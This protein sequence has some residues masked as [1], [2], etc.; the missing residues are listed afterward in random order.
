MNNYILYNDC[1]L[2]LSVDGLIYYYNNETFI[3]DL[4]AQRVANV[5]IWG[6]P[7]VFGNIDHYAYTHNIPKGE[8]GVKPTAPALK[9]HD[10][11][12]IYFVR[13]LTIA[14]PKAGS[15]NRHKRL[16]TV[17]YYNVQQ[18]FGNL[19]FEEALKA[20]NIPDVGDDCFKLGQ[21]ILAYE[22]WLKCLTG[23]DFFKP[24]G[25]LKYYSTGS[26]AKAYYLSLKY[27]FSPSPLKAY[28][29][30]FPQ[31]EKQDINFRLEKLLPR[32]VFYMKSEPLA[33]GYKYDINSLFLSEEIKAPALGKPIEISEEEYDGIDLTKWTIIFECRRIVF[34]AVN[35]DCLF[36]Q[37]PFEEFS[38][39]N[40]D[41]VDIEQPI[42][43]FEEYLTAI[44]QFYDII[45][46]EGI[47][48]YKCRK[49]KDTA[50]TTYGEHLYRVKRAENGGMRVIAKNLINFLH[51]KFSQI[52]L[53]EVYEYVAD[54][55]TGLLKKH[56]A[57]YD[58][59]WEKSHFHFIRGA[60]IYALAAARLINDLY[61]LSKSFSLNRIWYIDTDCLVT[62]IN[63]SEFSKILPLSSAALGAY[64]LEEEF[65]KF[66]VLAAKNYIRINDD[67]A[68]ALTAA[69]NDAAEIINQALLATKK[70]FFNA[71]SNDIPAAYDFICSGKVN[72]CRFVLKRTL[73]GIQWDDM[74]LRYEFKRN[75][76]DGEGDINV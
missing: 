13:K 36:F 3:E 57:D 14:T 60:Y 59:N 75:D 42:A 28:Q 26:I 15:V 48:L 50:I 68:I 19:T 38:G 74:L 23:L 24:N 30:D 66:K 6:A 4:A 54:D 29:S 39:K 71:P 67:G 43:F 62:D 34:K 76:F 52:S 9:R 25:G 17:N 18:F 8:H 32:Q 46:V 56:I 55:T 44:E 53:N 10:A 49:I 33:H 51:G 35:N 70:G 40:S 20:F 45:D 2:T 64:K 69:G 16:H 58:G 41:I 73:K 37:N 72:Y 1:N 63:P 5:Y 12:E 61:K 65:T 11:G 21:L 22:G 27:P 31:N 47:K 7:V